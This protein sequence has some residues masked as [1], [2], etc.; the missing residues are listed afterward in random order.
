MSHTLIGGYDMRLLLIEDNLSIVK[1]LKY[2]LAKQYDLDIA[3][4][5]REATMNVTLK[6]YDLIILDVMLP[7]G[8]GFDFYHDVVKHK[9]IPTLFLTAKDEEE[10]IVRGLN[11][12]AEDY[13]TKPFST[14]VLL[15]RLQ[16]IIQRMN[17]SN[18]VRV[19]DV[20]FDYNKMTIEKAGEII[21]LT[22]LE[23][24]IVNLMFTNINKVVT[25]A[26]ILESIWEWTGN[27]VDDHT[28][29][30]YIK[31][32]KDKIGSDVIKTVKGIGY[33]IDE[34]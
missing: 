27:D 4:S 28:V 18:V 11:L 2:A 7:D 22:S 31:R 14:K 16:R 25:R 3:C 23:L 5:I 1:G 26:V 6:P 10:D 12:G 15:A 17:K 30:V 20:T 21:D 33:R 19:H 32:I 13:I 9:Q 29:T 8:N 34:E 24:K